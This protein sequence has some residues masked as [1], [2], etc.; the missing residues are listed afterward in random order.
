MGWRNQHDFK[1]IFGAS[2]LV[3]GTL[4]SSCNLFSNY[5]KVEGNE[6]QTIKVNNKGKVYLVN[7]NK[8]KTYVDH[9]K[10]WVSKIKTR[11]EVE[12]NGT[13]IATNQA[14][15]LTKGEYYKARFEQKNREIDN[16]IQ[17]KNP[18]AA[19]N[20]PTNV[21]TLNYS[22]GN[23]KTFTLWY[24]L[25][26]D[27]DGSYIIDAYKDE[28]FD[29]KYIGKHCIVWFSQNLHNDATAN[30]CID[31]GKKFDEIYEKEVGL[32]G[33]N[34]YTS[35]SS[36]S[37]IDPQD[38]IELVFVDISADAENGNV[39]GYQSTADGYYQSVIANSFNNYD[40]DHS[41]FNVDP[42]SNE[43]QCIYI[44][45]YFYK[46]NPGEL[47]STLTHEFNH[48]LNYCQKE[49]QRG[50]KQESWYTEMLSMLTEDCFQEYIGI[51]DFSS[52]KWRLIPYMRNYGFSVSPFSDFDITSEYSSLQYAST[53]A[54]GAYIARNFGGIELVHEIATNDLVNKNSIIAAIE[55][56]GYKKDSLSAEATFKDI[57][58]NEP[59]FLIN[60]DPKDKE[61]LT[62]LNKDFSKQY[63]T[64]N[65][66]WTSDS[67]PGLSLNNIEI[68][69]PLKHG[70]TSYKYEPKFMEPDQEYTG[71]IFQDGF[72]IYY[73]GENIKEFKIEVAEDYDGVYNVIYP[74][75][76]K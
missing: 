42:K 34:K 23:T 3:L 11:R 25:D 54:F 2:I 10:L 26:V 21:R 27:G 57:L 51:D 12:E 61:D 5:D 17:K 65:R 72:D 20:I 19:G 41:E 60:I 24:L 50:L 13:P 62:E 8:N 15:P 55:K 22:V 70:T 46:R 74:E 43:S 76:K 49:I 16:R 75:P 44:D 68:G 14:D 29:C 71:G 7:W 32:I 59:Y 67:F 47:Y 64:L 56:L 63:L 36:S 66:K 6:T 18:R 35:K 52:P 39:L 31:L 53:Y 40:P 9:K 30:D 37:Y 69:K 4:F 58:Y 33:T 28:D 38:K 45:T 1:V 48:L 73:I